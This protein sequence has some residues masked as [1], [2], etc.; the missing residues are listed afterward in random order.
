M[1]LWYFTALRDPRHALTVAK[2]DLYR[3]LNLELD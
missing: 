3:Q 1:S 2:L